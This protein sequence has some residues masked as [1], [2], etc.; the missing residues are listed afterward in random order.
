[1]RHYEI[2]LIV[3]PDQSEQVPA[4]LDK[5]QKMITEKGG[6]VHRVEDWGRRVLAHPILKLHKAHYLLV[7]IEANQDE[8]NELVSNFKF[9]DAVLRHLI[10]KRDEAITSQSPLGQEREEELKREEAAV[11]TRAPAPQPIEDKLPEVPAIAEVNKLTNK[12]PESDIDSATEAP[13]E[14]AVE[15]KDATE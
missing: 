5:Y 6:L 10:I 11:K 1:M 8:L 13:K 4:M 7:N 2:V 14:E 15:E 9:N 12:E 3:H